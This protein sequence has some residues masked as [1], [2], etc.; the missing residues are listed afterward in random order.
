MNLT[1]EKY[2]WLSADPG[3]VSWKHEGDK[4]IVFERANLL[5][6]F[7]F[8]PTQSFPDYLVGINGSGTYSSVL[9]S[10]DEKFGGY[11]RIDPNISYFTFAEGYA[12]RT[13]SLKVK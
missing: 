12:G 13:N 6:L 11:S 4:V 7:N 8:H 3:Y 9:C 5:F 1:E 2:G 10:D